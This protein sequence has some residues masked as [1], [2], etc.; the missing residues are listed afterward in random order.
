MAAICFQTC[1]E[2]PFL[3]SSANNVGD[4]WNVE[5]FF[6]SK[7]SN[8][9]LHPMKKPPAKK[10]QLSGK[11][12]ITERKSDTWDLH[13]VVVIYGLLLALYSVQSHFGHLIL[14]KIRFQKHYVFWKMATDFFFFFWN[15]QFKKKYQQNWSLTLW[16]MGNEKQ[17]KYLANSYCYSDTEWNLPLRDISRNISEVAFALYC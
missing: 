8:S 13:A 12:A 3:W 11:R 4:S 5:F 1:A 10:N 9:P 17:C 2:F 6:F 16:R 14:L 15:F 7:I